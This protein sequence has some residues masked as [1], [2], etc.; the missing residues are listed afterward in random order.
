MKKRPG[1]SRV[2]LGGNDCSNNRKHTNDEDV[3]GIKK[4]VR[5]Y[6][7]HEK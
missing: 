3:R 2:C 1:P 5:I 6:E 4:I 7:G